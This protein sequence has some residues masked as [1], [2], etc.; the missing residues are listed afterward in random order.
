MVSWSAL[1]RSFGI[2]LLKNNP[3]TPFIV[4]NVNFS[5]NK[6]LFG[7]H[8]H[9]IMP[10]QPSRYGSTVSDYLTTFYLLLNSI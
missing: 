8:G 1:G 7:D 10:L 2:N 4:Q 5:I 3:R 9:K 6:A